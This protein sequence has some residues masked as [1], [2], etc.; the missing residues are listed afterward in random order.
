VNWKFTGDSGLVRFDLII[1]RSDDTAPPE[2]EPHPASAA[3]ETAA[4]TAAT[5]A[6]APRPRDE[7]VGLRR[8]RIIRWPGRRSGR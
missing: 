3:A 7:G 4:A 5:A 2:L 1:V 8:V 6:A